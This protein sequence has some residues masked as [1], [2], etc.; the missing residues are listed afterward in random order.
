MNL[1]FYFLLFFISFLDILLP[2][3]CTCRGLLLHFIT[4]STNTR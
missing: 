4:F 3:L 2:N 1:H